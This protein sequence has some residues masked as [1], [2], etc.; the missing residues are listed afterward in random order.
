MAW[1]PYVTDEKENRMCKDCKSTYLGI[2]GFSALG[3]VVALKN[4]IEVLKYTSFKNQLWSK[5]TLNPER[6]RTFVVDKEIK[7]GSVD[8]R[9]YYVW[10]DRHNIFIAD[11]HRYP[12]KSFH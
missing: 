5:S 10:Q 8:I 11:Y 7:T 9:N 2:I 4:I 6:Y 1:S 12:V 3:F